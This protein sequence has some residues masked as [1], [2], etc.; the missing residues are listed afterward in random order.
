LLGNNAEIL[1][2]TGKTMVFKFLYADSLFDVPDDTFVNRNRDQVLI[3]WE[4]T[5]VYALRMAGKN[6]FGQ[7]IVNISNTDK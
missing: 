7:V 1:N 6:E 5:H 2:P 3:A 4:S